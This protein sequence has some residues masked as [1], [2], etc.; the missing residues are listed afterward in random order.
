MLNSGITVSAELALTLIVP[1]HGTVPLVARLYSADDPYA[2]R[3]GPRGHRR[4]VRWIFTGNCSPAGLAT[5]S[6]G[7]VRVWP[8]SQAATSA[9]HRVVVR[10]ATRMRPVSATAEFLHRTY[11]IV[12]GERESEFINVDGG[13][14]KLLWRRMRS[15]ARK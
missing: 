13:L 2:I 9:E 15:S 7:D 6:D 10:S 3:H 8:G 12:E 14:D 4:A 1:A 11:R 5:T